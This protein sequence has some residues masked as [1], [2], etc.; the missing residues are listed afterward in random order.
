[1]DSGEET[2]QREGIPEILIRR[3]EE[4][5]NS[6]YVNQISKK[7]DQI[8]PVCSD[9][10]LNSAD[11]IF[12]QLNGARK[13]ALD[14]STKLMERMG[15]AYKE[16]EDAIFLICHKKLIE[17]CKVKN[18]S[19]VANVNCVLISAMEQSAQSTI[20][21]LS[22][23]IMLRPDK[24]FYVGQTDDLEGRICAHRLKEGM[25]NAS[26]LY[27]LVPGKSTTCQLETLLI[28]RLPDYGFQLTNI[29]DGRNH[30]WSIPLL[31][32]T[33]GAGVQNT[34]EMQSMFL[35]T[36]PNGGGKSSLLRSLCAAALLGMCG[37]MVPAE[38]AVI[39]H[40]DSIMLHMKSYDSP[41]D[42]KSSFQIEMSEIRSLVTGATLRSLV[43][44]D[45]ICPGTETAKGTCIAG[46]VIETLD[47]I[48]CLGIVSTHL[49]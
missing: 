33:R 26:F 37:F 22:V 49:H 20:G 41:A 19:E 46:S 29:A 10:D 3:A 7:K 34:V 31:V 23:Y 2:A 36:G 25:E 21:A 30:N 24:K 15:S 42:G 44:I 27:F 28:N 48:G 14:S 18:A 4:L 47:A 1:M 9:F 6:A 39:P 11:K 17:L 45:E 5:Y 38:S 32:A 13:I 16:L 40:F 8:R 35:V 43:L 12:D